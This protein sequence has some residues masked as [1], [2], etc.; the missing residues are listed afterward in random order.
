M[1]DAKDLELLHG[2]FAEQKQ[3]ILEESAANMRVILESY[4][5]PQFNALAEG[6]KSIEGK[7]TP[8]S[9]IEEL[10]SEIDFLKM[11]VRSLSQDIAELKKAQ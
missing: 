11:I 7:L 8:K 9:E 10:H 1:L 3:V 6:L 4:M 5:Q 2:M